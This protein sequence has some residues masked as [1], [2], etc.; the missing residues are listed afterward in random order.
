MGGQLPGTLFADGPHG[1]R[2]GIQKTALV[3][4][5]LGSGQCTQPGA[6]GEIGLLPQGTAAGAEKIPPEGKRQRR[7]GLFQLCLTS[8]QQ[9]LLC[10]LRQGLPGRAV[11]CRQKRVIVG[12]G[13]R[14]KLQ[15]FSNH[16]ISPHRLCWYSRGLRPVT[17][18]NTLEK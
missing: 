18:L 15:T 1:I 12:Q 17:F 2:N 7:N 5:A 14:Q 16:K 9:A 10:P 6:A 3:L 8:L 4:H 13:V 11:R